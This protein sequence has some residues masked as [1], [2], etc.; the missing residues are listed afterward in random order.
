MSHLTVEQRYT[1]S[2]MTQAGYSQ[3][4]ISKV[5]GRDKSVVSRELKRNA[6]GR[7]GMYHFELACRKAAGRQQEKRKHTRFTPDV[8]AFV[9][10]MLLLKYSPEQIVGIAKK[11]ALPC[12][13][14][15][16]IYQH[17]WSDKKRKGTL[18]THLRSKGKRYRNRSLV[19]DKRG[20]IVGRVD[21]SERPMVVEERKRFGD[22]EVDTIVGKDHKGAI[23]TINDRATGVLR[24]KKLNG[25][26]ASELAEACICV[27]SSWK[28]NLKTITADNGKEFADHQAIA[29]GLGVDFYFAK[30]Y[31]SWERGSNENLNGLIRQYIPKK[32]DFSTITEE[33][34]QFV[35]DQ[36]NSRPRK[37][38]NFE[39][40]NYMLNQKVAFVT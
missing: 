18:H 30:P 3:T 1:I 6:D 11:E 2:E 34:V 19:R 33:Y 35:E 21:I 20:R 26:C 14:H 15:E 7:S 4:A 5:I 38:F 16:R 23:L 40:P 12:V 39:T 13:S 32:T 8:Q 25:K 17:I 24:M 29:K 28:P 36:L 10:E 22:L 9:E 37:R 31:H 27:L